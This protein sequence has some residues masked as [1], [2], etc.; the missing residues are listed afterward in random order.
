M[1][2]KLKLHMLT[3]QE[4]RSQRVKELEAAREA[5][6]ND[7]DK[8]TIRVNNF[9]WIRIRKGDD[10]EEAIKRFKRVHKWDE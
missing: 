5:Q 2:Q 4:K 6:L 9:T 3:L 8:I 7:N 1:G 10:P